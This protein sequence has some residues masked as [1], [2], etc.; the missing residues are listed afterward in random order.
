M[1]TCKSMVL[2]AVLS[3]GMLA[4]SFAAEPHVVGWLWF[5]APIPENLKLLEDGL[6]K[7]GYEP[8]RNVVVEVRHVGADSRDFSDAARKLLETRPAVV[9]AP[10]GP[11]Q[12]AI[13]A[14][15]RSLPIV[16]ICAD[17]KNFLGEVASF[18]QPGGAT[19]GATFLAPESMGKR[20]EL[21][22]EIHPGVKRLAVLHSDDDWENYWRSLDTI[23]PRLGL[24]VLRIPF[25][26]VEDLDAAFAVASQQNADAVYA[27]PDGNTVN[28]VG[29]IAEL[30]LKY[31]LATAF[32][33][34]GAVEAG[35]LFSYG[36]DFSDLLYRVVPRFI[37]RILKGAKPGDLPIEQPTK[38]ELIVN[39]K[40]AR[41]LGLKV[42]AS[43]LLRAD[44]VI[45]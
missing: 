10:C 33:F 16:A 26:R 18:R 9:Y 34:S 15:S 35:G 12:R 30:G 7:L 45:E 39:L 32:D 42:P 3:A 25:K 27:L 37:D 17:E 36:S 38:F 21:L 28:A 29:R 11:A 2:T 19:T 13:R 8:G 40:T 31:R 20:L 41:M 43:I 5:R 1:P 24:T 6:R 4:P 44:R 14:I 23:A 22:K